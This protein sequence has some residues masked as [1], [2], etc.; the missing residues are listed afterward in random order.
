MNCPHPILDQAGTKPGRIR[1]LGAHARLHPVKECPGGGAREK[2]NPAWGNPR[3]IHLA[4]CARD[5]KFDIQIGS[6]CP[7]MKQIRDVFR[8]DFSMRPK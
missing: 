5:L 7:Q 6:N 4:V 2:T 1:A 3:V 8:S